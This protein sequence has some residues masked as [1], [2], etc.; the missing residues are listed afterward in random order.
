MSS[1]FTKNPGREGQCYDYFL[2]GEAALSYACQNR[3]STYLGRLNE[4]TKTD[5]MVLY[6]HL[7]P[8]TKKI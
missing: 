3:I 8:Q 4:Q 2:H 7:P 1:L 5:R 6:H